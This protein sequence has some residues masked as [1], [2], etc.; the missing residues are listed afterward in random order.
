LVSAG[1]LGSTF[2]VSFLVVGSL[3]SADF[4]PLESADAFLLLA[5]SEYFLAYFFLNSTKNLLYSSNDFLALVH[6]PFLVA[7]WMAFLLI[8]SGVT[9]L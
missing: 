3:I 9:N 4:F 8:L 2:L 5:A 6:L 7:L 1:F